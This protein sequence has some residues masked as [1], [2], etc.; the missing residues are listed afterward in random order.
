M[1][2]K[3]QTLLLLGL[4]LV[5]CHSGNKEWTLERAC[6]KWQ[7]QGFECVDYEGWDFGFGVPFTSY[8]GANIWHRL[9]KVPDNG[10]TYSGYMRRWGEE[11]HVYGPKAVEAIPPR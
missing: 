3:L 2:L 10:I 11:I 7:A 1:R 6:S 8:G 5:S 4:T 9:K